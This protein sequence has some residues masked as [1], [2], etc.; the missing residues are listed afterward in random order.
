MVLYSTLLITYSTWIVVFE[1]TTLYSAFSPANSIGICL[2]YSKYEYKQYKCDNVLFVTK[3]L[4]D[5]CSWTPTTL[6]HE[7]KVLQSE[8]NIDAHIWTR[9]SW[10]NI[11]KF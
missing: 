1:G 10:T 5:N 11:A 6:L 7:F 8:L 2:F 9:F 3:I 4:A